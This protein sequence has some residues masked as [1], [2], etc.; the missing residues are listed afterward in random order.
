M[1]FRNSPQTKHE[2]NG[3]V[4]YQRS[5]VSLNGQ[6]FE[7][8]AI[9]THFIQR[10][11]SYLDVI[12]KYVVPF[13]EEGDILSISE[14]I[15]SMCQNNVVEKKDVKLGFWAKFLSKF[16]SSNNHGIA[17]DEPYKLQLAINIAGL[18]RILW[19]C[20]CS[21]VTKL[22]GKR[23]MFYKIAGHGIDGIDGFY[24]GSS[25]ELYHD[26]AL[27]NPKEPVKVCNE[28]RENC[29]VSCMIVDANDLS[30]QI[31]GK[32]D[33]LQ[34]MSD[35]ALISLIK[36][37]PAGQSDELT[38]LILIK[39]IISSSDETV[40]NEVACDETV[41]NENADEDVSV[42]NIKDE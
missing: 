8:R 41:C 40:C 12:N 37:N 34:S 5:N 7:R 30:V 42:N 25:F 18:P 15:M 32:S 9:Q 19:A 36:D 27:L 10:G 16:A 4:Y 39:P 6:E 14:K 22:F 1:A 13:Y 20:V 35:E 38:P 31:F 29:G 3:I 26:I 24:M 28:I 17:M 23:G 2:E 33:T 21:A 11:E